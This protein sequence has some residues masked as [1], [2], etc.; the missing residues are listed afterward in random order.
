MFVTG[1]DECGA[2]V[3]DDPERRRGGGYLVYLSNGEMPFLRVSFSPIFSI[4]GYQKKAIFL[5]PVVK[6]CQKGKFC[7]IL[8]SLKSIFVFWS[9]LFTDFS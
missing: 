3:I 2:D 7:W 4:M 8:L 5:E 6:K 9:I 1:Q